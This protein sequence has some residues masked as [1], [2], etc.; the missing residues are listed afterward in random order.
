[1]LISKKTAAECCSRMF[2]RNSNWYLGMH[3]FKL[4]FSL[5]LISFSFTLPITGRRVIGPYEDGQKSDNTK[6]YETC[7]RSQAPCFYKRRGCGNIIQDR[8]LLLKHFVQSGRSRRIG[9]SPLQF[10]ND[11]DRNLG[12]LHVESDLRI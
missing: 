10:D 3:R 1:M 8:L 2:T 9:N 4:R 12:D 6:A 7:G 11:Q 5:L